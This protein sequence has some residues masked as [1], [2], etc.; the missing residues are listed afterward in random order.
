MMP[1]QIPALQKLGLIVKP[2]PIVVPY[3]QELAR[4]CQTH[5]IQILSPEKQ[6]YHAP[7]TQLL[8]TD[9]LI[10]EIGLLVVLGGDGTM[11]STSRLLKDHSLPVLGINLGT[12][13]YLMEF[14]CDQI[15]K[16]LDQ[17]MQGELEVSPRMVLESQVFRKGERVH[18]SYALNDVVIAGSGISRLIEVE[19][20][21]DGNYVTHVRSDGLIL[22]TP[23][24]STAYSLSAGG[25]LLLPSME[26][27]CMTPI[28]PISL[29]NR[30]LVLEQSSQI[31]LTVVS[32][33]LESMVTLDGQEAFHL[34][35]QDILSIRKSKKPFLLLQTPYKNHFRV[36]YE[37]LGWSGNL[38][39]LQKNIPLA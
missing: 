24:G 15:H 36:L 25:P 23:T 6:I 16:A 3:I 38:N 18:H 30:P 5:K 22:A 21:I 12:L 14:T 9:Q 17:Y 13:G 32:D 37:K 11:I 1:F 35:K 19:C 29:T 2:H 4:W 10:R 7:Q 34:Q 26:A 20:R 33:H 28:C 39:S 8:P 27:I 31:H